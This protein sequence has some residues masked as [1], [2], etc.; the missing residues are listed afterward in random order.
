MIL[1][2]ILQWLR[3][4]TAKTIPPIHPYQPQPELKNAHYLYSSNAVWRGVRRP[5]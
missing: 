4:R 2:Y 5:F 3:K 1:L